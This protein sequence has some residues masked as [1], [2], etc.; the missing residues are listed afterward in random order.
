MNKTRLQVSVILVFILTAC[1]QAP[2][3]TQTTPNPTIEQATS[4]PFPLPTATPTKLLENISCLPKPIQ[5]AGSNGNHIGLQIPPELHD[6][7][8]LD[9][10][11]LQSGSEFSIGLSLM[12]EERD[13]YLFWLEKF[14]NNQNGQRFTEVID[15]II[16]PLLKEGEFATTTCQLNNETVVAT[17]YYREEII[18]G[19]TYKKV[20]STRA[21]SI[22]FEQWT[23]TEIPVEQLGNVS[24]TYEY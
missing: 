2:S 10:L 8:N 6:I 1:G 9:S 15:E 5:I 17:G 24:C 22:N 3:A 11:L 20:T 14:C 21:W 16:L 4:T 12:L 7:K 13:Q 19:A 23:F 18:S